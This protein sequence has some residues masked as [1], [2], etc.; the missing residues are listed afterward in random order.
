MIAELR[1]LASTARL[2][3]V[4]DAVDVD[5]VDGRDEQ[6]EIDV[7]TPPGYALRQAQTFTSMMREA[8]FDADGVNAR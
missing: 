3:V 5:H 8:G 1:S 6:D 4:E 2:G 7:S